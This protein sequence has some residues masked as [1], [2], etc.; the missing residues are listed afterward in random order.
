MAACGAGNNG[1]GGGG[2]G[3]RCDGTVAGN[4][5]A[6][7]STC[8]FTWTEGAD[9]SG[10]IGGDITF[11]SGVPLANSSFAFPVSGDAATGS[12]GS[13][14]G[15]SA[16][17]VDQTTNGLHS[18]VVIHNSTTAIGAA[19]LNVTSVVLEG[20]TGASKLWTLHGS[21]SAT[22]VP[23]PNSGDSGSLVVQATF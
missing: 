11:P 5:S 12:Y 4:V 14:T 22:L 8:G 18:F 9:R 21:L 10:L 13:P 16:C 2:G 20:D 3:K 23:L 19:T 1:G 7:F 6:T 15:D 17:E